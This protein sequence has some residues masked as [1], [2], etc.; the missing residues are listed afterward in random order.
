MNIRVLQ[1]VFNTEVRS[2]RNGQPIMCSE[3]NPITVAVPPR[4]EVRMARKSHQRLRSGRSSALLLIVVASFAVAACDGDNKVTGPSP[5]PFQLTF[6]LD[7]SFQ[8]IHGG[9]S[10]NIAV[11]RSSSR[12]VV[13][14]GGG[15]VSAT[16]APSFTFVAGAVLERGT[17]YEVHYWIDSNFGGG[18]AG[19]CD[20]KAIDHQWSVE[21]RSV[22][23]DIVW[24]ASHSPSLTED[25]C[26]TFR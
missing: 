18:A 1:T 24:T 15:I 13:A 7:A 9:Q 22:S 21:F 3:A 17:D 12:V 16:Q 11:L 8:G 14:R 2:K 25:V 19:A 5:G 20:A 23:N 4:R 10:V 6:L 26:G